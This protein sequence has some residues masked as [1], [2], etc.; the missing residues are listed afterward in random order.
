[1]P[2]NQIES[3]P[4]PTGTPRRRWF[5]FSLRTLLALVT[6]VACCCW[7]LWQWRIVQQRKSVITE[8]LGIVGPH[9]MQ[10]Y[11]IQTDDEYSGIEMADLPYVR[12]RL[13]DF[14]ISGI[15]MPQSLDP[16][17][18]QRVAKSF[19]EAECEITVESDAVRFYLFRPATH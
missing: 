11:T 8:L 2:N 17:L 5:R 13:G 4:Q 1:M 12:R 9:Q 18:I 7:P 6:L 16:Q 14:A 10:Y 15:S 19:P 3:A